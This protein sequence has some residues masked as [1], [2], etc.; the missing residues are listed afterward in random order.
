MQIDHMQDDVFMSVTEAMALAGEAMETGTTE[1]LLVVSL[2]DD[3]DSAILGGDTR[4]DAVERLQEL[5][6]QLAE[7]TA[8]SPEVLHITG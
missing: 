2:S 7:R 5:L 8:E 3:G 6:N 1:T 4:P